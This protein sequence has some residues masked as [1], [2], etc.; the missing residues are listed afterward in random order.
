MC[1]G[2]EVDLFLFIELLVPNIIFLRRV[3]VV[4]G[5][6]ESDGSKT[7]V[8]IKHLG[9]NAFLYRQDHPLDKQMYTLSRNPPKVCG[10]GI[11]MPVEAQGKWKIK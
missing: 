3:S 2:P 1:S 7:E 11:R 6:S 5:D 10:V 8:A 4:K 9:A